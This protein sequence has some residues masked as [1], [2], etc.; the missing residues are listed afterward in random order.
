MGCASGAGRARR[1][2][3]ERQ[4]W[5][6]AGVGG[7]GHRGGGTDPG[8]SAQFSDNL[9]ILRAVDEECVRLV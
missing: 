1:T 3:P 7:G 8:W 5:S 6:R 9:L 4:G 2:F